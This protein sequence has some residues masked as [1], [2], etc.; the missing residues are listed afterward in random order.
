MVRALKAA[1]MLPWR[2]AGERR[3]AVVMR[4][5][6]SELSE[7]VSEREREYRRTTREK[8][9]VCS[10]LVLVVLVGFALHAVVVG[11]G[12]VEGV[13]AAAHLGPL[14]SVEETLPRTPVPRA[15]GWGEVDCCPM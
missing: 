13:R 2:W 1:M 4:A 10:H 9:V 8:N 5:D 3:G 14:G 15:D 7:R 6:R 11:V 12:R